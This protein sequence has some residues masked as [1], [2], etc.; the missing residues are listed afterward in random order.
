M[1]KKHHTQWDFFDIFAL[2]MVVSELSSIFAYKRRYGPWHLM[3]LGFSIPFKANWYY[4]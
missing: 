1:G 2:L 3:S 4:L